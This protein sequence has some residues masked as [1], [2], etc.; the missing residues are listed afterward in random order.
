M[1]AENCRLNSTINKIKQEFEI[2]LTN[3]QK[4]KKCEGT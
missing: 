2:D 4:M 3:E 1:F